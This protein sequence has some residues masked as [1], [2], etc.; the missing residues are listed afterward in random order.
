M[1]EATAQGGEALHCLRAR[2]SSNREGKRAAFLPAVPPR[3]SSSLSQPFLAAHPSSH[4]VAVWL[5]AGPSPRRGSA[6]EQRGAPCS[7][8]LTSGRPEQACLAAPGCGAP[9]DVHTANGGR[10]PAALLAWHLHRALLSDLS[11]RAASHLR[12]ASCP[13]KERR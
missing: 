5:N 3:W 2:L 13:A 8:C 12:A 1:V 9:G 6:G 4:L 10:G 11:K 7:A